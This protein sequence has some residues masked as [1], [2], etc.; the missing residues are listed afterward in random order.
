MRKRCRVSHAQATMRDRTILLSW[1]RIVS[2]EKSV[3]NQGEAKSGDWQNLGRSILGRQD[4]PAPAYSHRG[5]LLFFRLNWRLAASSRLGSR[6]V[7]PRHLSLGRAGHS[8]VFHSGGW[9]WAGRTAAGDA[10]A[11]P[12]RSPSADACEGQRLRALFGEGRY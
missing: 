4:L 5:G 1:N 6:T 3:K 7:T 9:R 12:V 8:F 2:S 11:E 10:S